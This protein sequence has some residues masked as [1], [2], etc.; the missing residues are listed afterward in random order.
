MAHIWAGV[1]LAMAGFA[2][3]PPK[4][5][6]FPEAEGSGAMTRGGRG[7]RLIAVTHLGDSGPG[8]LRAAVEAEGPR[9]VVFRV[10]GIIELKSALKVSK[11]FLTI[12]GQT[13]PGGG[14][15][16]KGYGCSIAADEV[17]V[18]HLRFRP[19]DVAKEEV[20]SL[21]VYRARN[22]ILDHC[23]ASWSVDETLSVTGEGC[24]DVT[25]QWCLIT[26][27]LNKSVHPKGPHGYGS[28]IR[29]DGKITYHHNLYAHHTSRNPRP[30]TYGKEPGLLDFRNNVI[31]N[32][33]ARAGYSAGDPTHMNY[34]GNYL[35]PGPS[36]R[37]PD[38]AFRV[39]GAE[40][41]LFVAD[42]ALAGR[43]TD[44]PWT[45]ITGAVDGN[46]ARE[47]FAMA[48]VTTEKPDAAFAKVLEQAGATRPARDAV[49]RRVV[50]EVHKGA[51][52]II[53]SQNDVGGWPAYEAGEPPADG[54]GDGMPD[55][56]EKKYGLNPADA[57]DGAKDA[58]GD[59]Y[60][61][62]EEF[63]ND[64]DPLR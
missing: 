52:R 55:E 27:S 5:P 1:W 48:P 31:Y 63:L 56:W 39:G 50:E 47:A 45:L 15:C 4:V 54:D 9:V 8:S 24:G 10:G 44:D 21:A 18:R 17:I 60:T 61:N 51:G 62:V 34:V 14:I 42:N 43:E 25:V 23:S 64:T 53:D 59:G 11:P 19:G 46:K 38:H 49:D 7:G 16:L 33:G 22:V 6:A 12:A 3:E 28:L 2:Q 37:T 26:E 35:K 20:D 41:R 29:T 30:G 57:A 32:W 13:A 40:T 36:T 58:D